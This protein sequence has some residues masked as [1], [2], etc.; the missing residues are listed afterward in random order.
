MG[1]LQNYY[2]D[3]NSG[4]WAEEDPEHCRCNGSGWALSD[5]DTWH[6]CPIHF[7][8]QIHP[9]NYPYCLE[10]Y[11]GDNFPCS[12]CPSCQKR[13]QNEVNEVWKEFPSMDSQLQEE[14]NTP[15]GWE[16]PPF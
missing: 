3:F 2:D 13:V 14:D 6:M 15:A 9:E 5:L 8:N 7:K 10:C 1:E 4:Y 11:D 12:E 16:E